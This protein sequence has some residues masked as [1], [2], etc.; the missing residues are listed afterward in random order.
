MT[1]RDVRVLR[2]CLLQDDDWSRAGHHYAEEHDRHY[3]AVHQI[4]TWLS[5]LLLGQSPA[6]QA[7]RARAM[8]LLARDPSRLPD[9]FALGPETPVDDSVRRRLFG[10]E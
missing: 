9:L 10:E 7:R 4:D 2:D 6:A 5:S 1:L 3:G 8:P